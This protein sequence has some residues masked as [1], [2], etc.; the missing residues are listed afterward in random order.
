[1]VEGRAKNPDADSAPGVHLREDKVREGGTEERDR[2]LKGAPQ[3]LHG[4]FV[5]PNVMK[6]NE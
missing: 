2:L 1:M 3:S 6:D 5:L 4:F